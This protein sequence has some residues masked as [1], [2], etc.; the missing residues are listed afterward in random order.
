MTHVY[1][2]IQYEGVSLL[3]LAKLFYESIIAH[4]ENLTLSVGMEQLAEEQDS[5][6][7][8][9]RVI[10]NRIKQDK[11]LTQNAIVMEKCNCCEDIVMVDII[12]AITSGGSLENAYAKANS[13]GAVLCFGLIGLLESWEESERL[14]E[15][16]KLSSSGHI[17][18]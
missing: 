18:P 8:L 14:S 13:E 10:I 1:I 6:V 15:A 7:D 11:N 12:G 3:Q 17:R 16:A 5:R 2:D 9:L 4:N